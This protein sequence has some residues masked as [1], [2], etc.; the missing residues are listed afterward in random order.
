M[1]RHAAFRLA[2][3]LLGA[4]AGI[5]MALYV[6]GPPNAAFVLASLGGSAF[7]LFGLTRAPAAQLRAIFGGH[8]G[9]AC[10]GIACSQ[11]LGSSLLS[12][13]AAVSLSLGFM[14]L[15]RTVHPPAGA[16]PVIM[17]YAQAHWSAL[18]SPVLLGVVILVCTAIV[19]SR[20]Y[21][22]LVHYPVTPFEPSPP[23]VNWGGWQ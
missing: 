3:C 14:L 9:S 15:T 18:L 22:G 20:I 10:I 13:A 17:I 19:W 1:H 4:G 16:N 12:C 21:P 23:S 7:F 11:F 8:L 5:S 6:V 2:W